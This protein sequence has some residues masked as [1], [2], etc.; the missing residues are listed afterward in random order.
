MSLHEIEQMEQA[1]NANAI[2][3]GKNRDE[4]NPMN[5]IDCTNPVTVEAY[6]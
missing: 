6:Q 4:F 3:I 5:H 1:T 2:W